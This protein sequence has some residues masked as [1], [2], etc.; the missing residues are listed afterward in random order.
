MIKFGLIGQ[1]LEHS[2]SQSFFREYFQKNKIDADYLNLEFP[3]NNELETFFKEEIFEYKG[4]NV[5]IPYKESV[6]QCIDELTTEATSI[7]AIN[8]IKIANNTIIG[9]NTD[10][11]GFH[12]MIKPFITSQ[13][14]KAMIIGTGGASKSVAYVL[15]SIGIDVLFISRKKVGKNIFEYSDINKYMLQACKCIINTTPVGMYPNNQEC[16]KFPFEFLT[17]EHLVIDLIYNP[18]ET[19]FLKKA[20]EHNATILNGQT[21][22]REQAFESWKFWS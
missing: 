22:L 21:M 2:Y 4:L 3:S 5:T 17:S 20:K 1:K 7:G 15:K 9:H 18:E 16:I 6:L 19:L 14:Q 10:C 12:Q 11:F 8:T 13:H